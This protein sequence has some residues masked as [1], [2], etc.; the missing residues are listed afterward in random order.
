[1]GTVQGMQ[2]LQSH[3][4]MDK[5][6]YEVATTMH[7]FDDKGKEVSTMDNDILGVEKAT[8]AEKVKLKPKLMQELKLK[9]KVKM[10][11]KLKLHNQVYEVYEIQKINLHTSDRTVV[12]DIAFPYLLE[13]VFLVEVVDEDIESAHS[14]SSPY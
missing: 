10:K 2:L 7:L 4:C 11:I 12:S 1:M 13:D 5:D 8:E 9:L 6:I 3:T 14:S